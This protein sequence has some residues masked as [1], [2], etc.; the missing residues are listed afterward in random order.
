MRY[1]RTSG[2]ALALHIGREAFDRRL[3]QLEAEVAALHLRLALTHDPV[4]KACLERIL[5]NLKDIKDILIR[6]LRLLDRASLQGA[7][8]GASHVPSASRPGGPSR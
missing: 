8:K 1:L 6:T 3:E 5:R 7:P 4:V 2:I